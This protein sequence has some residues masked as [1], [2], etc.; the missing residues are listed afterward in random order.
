MGDEIMGFEGRIEY[1]EETVRGTPNYSS[2]M[3]WIGDVREWSIKAEG[4]TNERQSFKARGSTTQ[5]R[6]SSIRSGKQKVTAKI[7]WALQA[8]SDIYSYMDFIAL[9]LGTSTGVADAQKAFTLN[10]VHK[11]GTAEGGMIGS[12]GAK[13]QIKC[14]IGED[15]MASG[16]VEC[17]SYDPSAPLLVTS[18]LS[19]ASDAFE[20]AVA[21]SGDILKWTDSGIVISGTTSDMVTDW[22]LDLDHR[23]NT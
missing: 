1:C 18:D 16:E 17:I 22:Q 6:P 21:A 13:L 9:F 4:E 3:V 19:G 23:L 11:E 12:V 8:S 20:Q 7:A 2:T 5:R 10:C 15:I 14:G